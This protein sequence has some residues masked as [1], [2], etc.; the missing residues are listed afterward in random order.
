MVLDIELVVLH[1]VLNN[2]EVLSGSK[3]LGVFL[4]DLVGERSVRVHRLSS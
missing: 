2:D 4:L 1:R 3:V